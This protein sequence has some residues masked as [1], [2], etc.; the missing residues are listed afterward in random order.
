MSAGAMR[1]PAP[2]AALLLLLL[3]GALALDDGL[4]RTPPMGWR[5]WNTFGG[6]V[7][8]QL[9]ED[10]MDLLVARGRTIDG[11]PTSLCDLGYCDVG[12]DDGWQQCGSYGRE[13]YTF[14]QPNG[15]PVVNRSRFPNFEAM[16][17]HAHALGLTAGW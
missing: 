15:M 16:T 1:L 11:V 10:T 6:D 7:D 17:A 2:A 3:E 4:A 14:H 9:M 12:L 8:Q 13:R 5:S